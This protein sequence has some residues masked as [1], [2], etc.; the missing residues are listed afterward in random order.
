MMIN[1]VVS[2]KR[3][4]EKTC[5]NCVYNKR[6]S[7]VWLQYDYSITV[8]IKTEITS[9]SGGGVLGINK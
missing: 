3:E 5:L 2:I 6:S 9:R 1:P 8:G 7:T 4:E